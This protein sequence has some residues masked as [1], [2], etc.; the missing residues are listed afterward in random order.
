MKF[1]CEW[2]G[3]EGLSTFVYNDGRETRDDRVD[4]D[5]FRVAVFGALHPRS[6]SGGSFKVGHLGKVTDTRV[7]HYVRF[8]IPYVHSTQGPED[9]RL[10]EDIQSCLDLAMASLQVFRLTQLRQAKPKLCQSSYWFVLT[11][12]ETTGAVQLVKMLPKL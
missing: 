5:R 1:N 10:V 12:L 7:P 8:N 4:I 3:L 6:I 9:D 2:R 11:P